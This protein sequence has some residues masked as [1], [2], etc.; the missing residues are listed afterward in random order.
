MTTRTE[1]HRTHC[2]VAQDLMLLAAVENRQLQLAEFNHAVHIK[3]A[4]GYLVQV[5]LAGACQQM[6]ATLR[7]FLQHHGVDPKKF[8]ATM[9]E[10]WLRA[11][12]HFMQ[13]GPASESADEFLQQ[14]PVLLNREILLSH[15][16]HERLF[17]DRARQR[18][19]EPDLNP[20]PEN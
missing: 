15:Y 16:S 9:T 8:H 18:Y 20:F 14:N 1:N 3:V 6:P 19:V 10:G 7:G 17:S 5:G 4:Y 11:I 12:W 13:H 2:L